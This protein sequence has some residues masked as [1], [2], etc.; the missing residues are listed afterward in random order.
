[1]TS[2][3]IREAKMNLSRLLRQVQEGDEIV[4]TD[5]GRAVGKIIPMRSVRGSLADL[6]KD[7][8]LRGV[9]EKRDGPA[10][11]PPY[12]KAPAGIAQRF[13]QEDRDG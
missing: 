11:L 2:V 12:A 13:L 10:S 3:G 8:E 7:L 1:M 5:H 4:I 6:E 9:I